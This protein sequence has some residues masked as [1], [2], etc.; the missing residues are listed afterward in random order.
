MSIPF[1]TREPS[2]CEIER[3]RLLMSVFRD[4]SGQERERDNT[5]RPGWRD[6]E[7]VFADFLAGHA[8]ENKEIFDVIVSST[9]QRN[10]AYGISLKSKELSR[11]S[12]LEDLE[13]NGRVYMELCNSP[14]KLWGPLKELQ[15]TEEIFRE[16]RQDVAKTVGDCIIATIKNWHRDTKRKYEVNNPG[17]NLDLE[18]S[19]YITVSSNIKNSVRSYQVHSFS[20]S[21]PTDLVWKF[22]SEKCLRGYDSSSPE[23]IVFDWYG[24]SGGQLKY[25]PKAS[26]AIYKSPIFHL[27]QPPIHTLSDRAKECWP[28]KWSSD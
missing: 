28:D 19:K 1:L 15:L 6:L 25:Y 7:R 9:D 16:K 14:A 4:G 2:V 11:A 26:E 5:S 24:L 27:E 18:K 20:L 23:E 17:E 3:L 13:N 12:A 21:L 22:S 10:K 8:N